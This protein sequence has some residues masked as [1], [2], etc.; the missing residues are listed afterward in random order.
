MSRWIVLLSFAALAA[1]PPQDKQKP[2]DDVKVAEAIRRGVEWLKGRPAGFGEGRGSPLEL[3]LLTLLHG[4]VAENDPFFAAHF[5]TMLDQKP[6]FTYRTALRAMV[7][8]EAQRVRYQPQIFQ[9]AQYLVDNQSS[10][11]FWGYGEPTELPEMPAGSVATGGAAQG[12]IKVYDTPGTREKPKVVRRVPVTQRRQGKEHD[13]SNS[14]YAAL[15]LRAC[16][17]AGIVIPQD[18]TDRAIKWL[19]ESQED[20]AKNGKVATGGIVASPRGWDYKDGRSAYG[21]MTAGSV[22]A[23]A[24]YLYIQGKNWK[25]DRD[26]AEGVAWLGAN[27]SVSENPKKGAQWHYYYLY[28]LERAGVLY[29]TP[30]FGRHDWYT[31][32]AWYLLENQGKDGSWKS[33]TDTCFAILFLKRAT[34]PLVATEAAGSRKK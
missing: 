9:C 3:V 11:G 34:R 18:V 27:F 21:S 31:E 13:N 7:L 20:G 14:Q 32:G 23:L 6:E 26:L 33:V 2:P 19:R 29:D 4:G 22:G 28:G 1:S 5:K 12:G 17:D 15:G 16:H 25:Q 30:K 8:E 10:R 24:I